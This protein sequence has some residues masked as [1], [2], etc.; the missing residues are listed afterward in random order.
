MLVYVVYI[1]MLYIQ[2]TYIYICIYI[3][4]HIVDIPVLRVL[5]YLFFAFLNSGAQCLGFRQPYT[6]QGRDPWSTKA[7]LPESTS[8]HL[9]KQ[10]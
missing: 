9:N 10:T 3:Y 5:S 4:M 6:P 8:P 1:Y 7:Q 2:V